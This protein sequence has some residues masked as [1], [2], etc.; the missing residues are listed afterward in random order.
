MPVPTDGLRL[1]RSLLCPSPQ[2]RRNSPSTFS[3]PLF[4][5]H[6]S[7]ISVLFFFAF[8]LRHYPPSRASFFAAHPS[9]ASSA[10]LRITS[11][12]RPPR[13]CFD[14]RDRDRASIYLAS[15]T[16]APSPSAATGVDRTR[17]ARSPL[18]PTP[19]HGHGHTGLSIQAVLCLCVCFLDSIPA[20]VGFVRQ[21]SICS[22]VACS[23]LAASSD[24]GPCRDIPPPLHRRAR[25][26]ALLRY[27]PSSWP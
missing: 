3:H 4:P 27:P 25:V 2:P 15:K 11:S 23:P 12:A 6:H 9:S 14:R 22:L 10:D 1:L 17:L 8:I 19:R 21:Q 24:I 16:P 26:A 18:S 5:H 13:L 20:T 7:S